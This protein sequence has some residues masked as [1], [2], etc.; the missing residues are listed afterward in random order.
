MTNSV[1]RRP[2]RLGKIGGNTLLPRGEQY[3]TTHKSAVANY[4]YTI[5]Q[6]GAD[7]YGPTPPFS[8]KAADLIETGR[9]APVR[10]PIARYAGIELWKAMDEAAEAHCPNEESHFT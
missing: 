3:R 4:L 2:F 1:L 9:E 6:D 8:A 5:R 7:H 10:G